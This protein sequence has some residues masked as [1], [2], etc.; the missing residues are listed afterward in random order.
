MA[1]D[2]T[3]RSSGTK[4]SLE[5]VNGKQKEKRTWDQMTMAPAILIL[6]ILRTT[7]KASCIIQFMAKLKLFP[8]ATNT[9]LAKENISPTLM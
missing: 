1:R 4:F 7:M 8:K 3:S 6:A 9:S 2:R 5:G